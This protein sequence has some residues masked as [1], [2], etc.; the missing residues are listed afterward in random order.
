MPETYEREMKQL[1]KHDVN[2]LTAKQLKEKIPFQIVSDGEV[3][4]VVLPMK[5][6]SKP[7]LPETPSKGKLAELPL[8]KQRQ[9]R[10]ELSRNPKIV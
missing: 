8:S 3:I 6:Y 1:T 7:Q 4:A 5:D 2:K 9:A 10:C